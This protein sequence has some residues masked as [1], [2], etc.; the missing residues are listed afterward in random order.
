MKI[1]LLAATALVSSTFITTPAFAG[2]VTPPTAN[3]P[4]ATTEAAMQAQCDALAA[5]HD[6]L[7]GD[8]WTAAVVLGGVTQVGSTTEV[9][10]L[11]DIDGKASIQGTGTDVLGALETPGNPAASRWLLAAASTCSAPSGRLPAT[12]LTAPTTTRPIM[13]S[14][15][16]HAFSCDISQAVYHPEVIIPADGVLGHYDNPGAG[17]CGGRTPAHQQARGGYRS[18]HLYPDGRC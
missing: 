8:I 11:R 17:D 14:T 16:S 7:N 1:A 12:I 18:S 5:A 3:A 6:T 2:P 13:T 10:G 4:D 15:N 9:L